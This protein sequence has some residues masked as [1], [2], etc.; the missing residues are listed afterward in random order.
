MRVRR[1]WIYHVIRSLWTWT[2]QKIQNHLHCHYLHVPHCHP[3][4]PP[5]HQMKAL[6][7]QL[8]QGEGNSGGRMTT[9]HKSLTSWSKWWRYT[10]KDPATLH[11]NQVA[12]ELELI[13]DPATVSRLKKDILLN[14]SLTSPAPPYCTS[15]PTTSARHTHYSFLESLNDQWQCLIAFIFILFAVTLFCG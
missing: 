1:L 6:L 10:Q 15:T 12:V 8:L 2:C 13:N 11:H 5:L 7:L 4:L 14:L 3:H 9:K